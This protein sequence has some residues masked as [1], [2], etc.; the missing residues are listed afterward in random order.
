MRDEDL[1]R[2]ITDWD[3]LPLDWRETPDPQILESLFRTQIRRH[4]WMKQDMYE[5][6]R[7]KISGPNRT[8]VWLQQ[9]VLDVLK[10][11]QLENNQN[12]LRYEH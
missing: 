11:K 4:A 2:F 1:Q 8:Y 6:Q 9:R 10:L 7:M 5:Y 3:A 12:T